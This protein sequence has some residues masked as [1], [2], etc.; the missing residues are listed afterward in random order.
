MDYPRVLVMACPFSRWEKAFPCWKADAAIAAK[1]LLEN[2]FPLWGIPSKISSNLE[3]H[4]TG[5]VMKQL[6]KI[7][8][9]LWHHHCPYHPQCLGKVSGTS[10]ILRLKLAKLTRATGF[11]WPKVL[12]IARMTLRSPLG[13]INWHFMKSSLG[14]LGPWRQNPIH[15]LPLWSLIWP[16]TGMH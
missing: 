12:P 3:T 10:G 9:T 5:Q 16:N 8:L 4:F 2:V 6:N 14:D 15:T 7:M 1:K 11:P 13:N